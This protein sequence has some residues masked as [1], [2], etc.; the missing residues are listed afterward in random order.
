[1]GIPFVKVLKNLCLGSVY[2][3]ILAHGIKIG[4]M[5]VLQIGHREMVGPRVKM[6]KN[7]INKSNAI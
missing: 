4:M 7:N 6:E 2:T 3:Q 1:M 5:M